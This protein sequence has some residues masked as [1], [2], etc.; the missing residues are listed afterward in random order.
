MSW[1]LFAAFQFS[2]CC[3][4]RELA[5]WLIVRGACSCGM[6]SMR[7]VITLPQLQEFNRGRD[8]ELLADGS[9]PA[10]RYFGQ[11]RNFLWPLERVCGTEAEVDTMRVSSGAVAA[12]V[13][14]LSGWMLVACALATVAQCW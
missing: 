9:A 11:T 5:R 12:S 13:W 3:L 10:W 8:A 6:Q 1:T 4:H 7:D 14:M 2:S